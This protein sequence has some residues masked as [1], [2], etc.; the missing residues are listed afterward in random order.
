MCSVKSFYGV[1]QTKAEMSYCFQSTDVLLPAGLSAFRVSP[2]A[3]PRMI[4]R[5]FVACT[6][7]ASTSARPTLCLPESDAGTTRR[8]EPTSPNG[9]NIH[10]DQ[11]LPSPLIIIPLR[12]QIRGHRDRRR[13][14]PTTLVR[15]KQEVHF[16]KRQFT[17]D[18]WMDDGWYVGKLRE[19]PNVF[20]Q[21]ETL[22]E[23]QRNI[24]DAFALMR[25]ESSTMP[26][27]TSL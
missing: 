9:Y 22:E 8:N 10:A 17:L 19:V 24:Q 11:N 18:Y 21:G 26:A 5:R 15:Q 16:V 1:C 25:Q 3:S 20:S 23:L 2:P 6:A 7:T 14:R 13:I 4:R 27:Q 12:I